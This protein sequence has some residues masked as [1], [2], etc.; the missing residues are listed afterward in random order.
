MPGSSKR[1]STKIIAAPETATMMLVIDYFTG[2]KKALR[3]RNFTIV[4]L[5]LPISAKTSHLVLSLS[6]T[7]SRCCDCCLGTFAQRHN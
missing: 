2:L 7:V 1:E 6:T 3:R 4:R 5:V